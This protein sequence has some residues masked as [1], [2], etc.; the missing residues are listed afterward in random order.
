MRSGVL[1]SDLASG[2]APPDLW[3]DWY[4][5][6]SYEG[7]HNYRSPFDTEAPMSRSLGY[8]KHHNWLIHRGL[9]EASGSQERLDQMLE[10]VTLDNPPLAFDPFKSDP[11]TVVTYTEDTMTIEHR[12]PDT[13]LR[14][15]TESDII[16]AVTAVL[17]A[18]VVAG[19]FG[20][21]KAAAGVLVVLFVI[22]AISWIMGD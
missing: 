11:Y 10:Q 9:Y 4:D 12:E 21:F 2:P 7:F 14:Q 20:G 8:V 22:F 19:V 1:A 5:D 3:P 17:A 13:G 6:G 15:W 16:M 18:I